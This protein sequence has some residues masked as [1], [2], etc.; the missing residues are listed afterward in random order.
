ML[1]SIDFEI[2]KHG[3]RR[4]FKSQTT[5]KEIMRAVILFHVCVR[6]PFFLTQFDLS[7]RRSNTNGPPLNLSY[8][9]LFLH[10]FHV[11][12][13]AATHFDL[14]RLIHHT[15]FQHMSIVHSCDWT[16]FSF[17]QFG[18]VVTV[19]DRHV[20]EK[21]VVNRMWWIKMCSSADACTLKTC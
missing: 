18:P 20:S 8:M 10:V 3:L 14:P 16:I 6:Q 17:D 2:L 1:K 4:D 19:Y 5:R 12:R 11:R 9:F 13:G 21:L 7:K 15:F